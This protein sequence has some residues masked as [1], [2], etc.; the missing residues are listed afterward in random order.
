MTI[1]TG[2]M[3]VEWD[4][5]TS[6]LSGRAVVYFHSTCLLIY[7]VF[8]LYIYS[9]VRRDGGWCWRAGDLRSTYSLIS[10]T[11]LIGSS[12]LIGNPAVLQKAQITENIV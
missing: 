12:L 8:Y 3:A 2:C 11:S 4:K 7:P 1:L 9:S 10:M 5:S 6:P